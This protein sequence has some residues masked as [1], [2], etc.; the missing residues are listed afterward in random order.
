MPPPHPVCHPQWVTR[1]GYQY[2]SFYYETTTKDIA[3]RF[4]QADKT[5]ADYAGTTSDTKKVYTYRDTCR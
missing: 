5:L 1:Y 2:V 3:A 4:V